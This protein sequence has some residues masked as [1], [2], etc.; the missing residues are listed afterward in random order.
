VSSAIQKNTL[1]TAPK[2][3]AHAVAA[4]AIA[5]TVSRIDGVGL[6]GFLAFALFRRFV[7]IGDTLCLA[8]LAFALGFALLAVEAGR[9]IGRCWAALKRCLRGEG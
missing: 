3:G 6:S 1:M 5:M 9:S 4:T 8:G 2:T 7:F